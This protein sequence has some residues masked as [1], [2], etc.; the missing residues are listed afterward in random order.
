MGDKQKAKIEELEQE[1][2]DA[3]EDLGYSEGDRER[4]QKA[5]DVQ[6]DLTRAA[7]ELVGNLLNEVEARDETIK[8]LEAENTL[9]QGW[10][11]E[12]A[13][14]I[15][16]N[17]DGADGDPRITDGLVSDPSTVLEVLLTLLE[18]KN[19]ITEAASNFLGNL[20]EDL[21]TLGKTILGYDDDAEDITWDAFGL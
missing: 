3:W 5:L 12:V 11:A 21:L 10:L 17:L 4:L 20:A 18:Q 9:W 7:N 16:E 2:A 19:A 15:V 14:T 1:L 8:T 6:I 13:L